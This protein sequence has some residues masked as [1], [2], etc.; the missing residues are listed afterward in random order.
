M[1]FGHAPIIFP[2]VL[3]VDLLYHPTF[4]VPLALLHGSLIL[5]LAGDVTGQFDWVR[6]GGLLNALALAAFIVGTLSAVVCRRRAAR[7]TGRWR[8]QRSSRV[9]ALGQARAGAAADR[10]IT[11]RRV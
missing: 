11:S 7:M 3:R 5:R 10:F 4:Y 2:A 6:T 9:S 8:V 1:V